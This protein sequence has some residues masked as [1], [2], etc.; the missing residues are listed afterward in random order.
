ML[1]EVC[2]V[3]SVFRLLFVALTHILVAKGYQQ[4]EDVPFSPV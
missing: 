3:A 4:M 1:W 2:V